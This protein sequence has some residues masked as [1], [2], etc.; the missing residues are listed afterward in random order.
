MADDTDLAASPLGGGGGGGAGALG[1]SGNDIF[2][3]FGG[4]GGGG[5][6][7]GLLPPMTHSPHILI[8]E[9]SDSAV[10]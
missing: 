7:G 1:G 4:G 8:I 5:G 3:I 2:G 9:Y 10:C 6:A